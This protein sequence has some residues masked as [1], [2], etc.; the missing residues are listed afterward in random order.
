MAIPDAFEGHAGG[1]AAPY[2]KGAAVI[3]SDD[4]NLPFRTRAIWV[5]DGGDLAVQ[6]PDGSTSTFTAVPTGTLLS[7][8][9]DRVLEA[10]DASL[11]V[12]LG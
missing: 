6:W 10:T 1:L 7:I 5:G 11:I 8:R 9:V 12:A 3:P 2:T 4:N